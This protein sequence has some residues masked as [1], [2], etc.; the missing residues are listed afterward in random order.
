MFAHASPPMFYRDPLRQAILGHSPY[1]D[2]LRRAIL[3][4]R[5]PIEAQQPI[6][7]V[8]FTALNLSIATLLVGFQN[9]VTFYTT[10]YI[11]L[12]ISLCT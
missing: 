1:R 10:F 4:D 7:L 11:E 12:L 2:P 8:G 3:G 5:A 6:S 9:E